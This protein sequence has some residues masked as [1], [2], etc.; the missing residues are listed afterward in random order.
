MTD[1]VKGGRTDKVEGGRTEGEGRQRRGTGR[2]RAAGKGEIG[3]RATAR[4][5]SPPL[6]R[7][8]AQEGTPPKAPAVRARLL[9]LLLLRLLLQ[10]L[11]LQ[12]LQLTTN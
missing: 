1:K 4:T 8:A 10:L 9:V 2:R 5:T 7:F 12:L 3:D 6:A 11:L